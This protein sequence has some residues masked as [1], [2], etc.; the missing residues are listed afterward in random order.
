M[1]IRKFALQR[2]LLGF[3]AP[4]LW[5]LHVAMTLTRTLLPGSGI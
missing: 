3:K 5:T 1:E 4:K 2:T